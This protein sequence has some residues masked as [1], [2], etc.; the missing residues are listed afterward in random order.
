MAT[1][2][3]T[4]N[5]PKFTV[6]HPAKLATLAQILDDM[7]V[8]YTVIKGQYDNKAEKSYMVKG[9]DFDTAFALGQDYGQ[10]SILFFNQSN[11]WQFVYTNGID[12]GMAHNETGM[13]VSDVKPKDNFSIIN[14]KY[15]QISFDFSKL[16][17]AA[18]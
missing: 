1:A 2:I 10:E 6:A 14:G 17:P 13:T 4:D 16:V 7:G 3:L 5:N 9:I 11:T 8:K 12:E 18:A 15:V